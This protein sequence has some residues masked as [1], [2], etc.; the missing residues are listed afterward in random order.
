MNFNRIDQIDVK[1]KRVLIRVDMNVP[2]KNGVIG[3]DTRMRASLDTI[4]HCMENG[5]STIVMCHLGRPKEGEPTK[6]DDVTPI[7]NHLAELLGLDSIPVVEDWDKAPIKV[8][9]GK[10]VMLPNVRNNI[11]EKKDSDELGKK[12]A[13]LADIYVNDAFGTAHRAQASVHSVAKFAPVACAGLLLAKELDSLAQAKENP[14][15]PLIAIVGGSKVSTKLTVLDKLADFVDGLVVGGG[16]ANT[17]LLAEGHKVGKSL[18]EPELVEEAR[19][20]IAKMKAKN[21]VIPLPVDVVT[22]KNF[23]ESEKGVTKSIDDVEDDDMI[24]DIGPKSIENLRKIVDGAK[25]LIWNGPVG[26]FEFPEF[27]NGTKEL[28][29]AIAKSKAFCLAGGGDTLAAINEFDIESDI[30]YVSTGGGAFLEF[31]EGKTL[32]AVAILEK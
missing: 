18:C 20:I 14:S 24:M 28:S 9:A 19:K 3:D 11:G 26:V 4:K 13:S 23:S 8:D 29:L 27:A 31:L 10:V 5:A 32:P 1:G 12:Y 25:T 6:E 30:D 2:V 7:A 17:F 22:G 16:I 21:G 15:R